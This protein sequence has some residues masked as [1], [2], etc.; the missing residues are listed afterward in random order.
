MSAFGQPQSNTTTS[1]FGQ[2][3]SATSTFGNPAAAAPAFG[4]SSLIK[5]ATAFGTGSSSGGFSAFA[6][7]Q[8]SAFGL[9]AANNTG[10]GS[11]FGQTSTPGTSS[12]SPFATVAQSNPPSAFGAAAQNNQPPAFGSSSTPSTFGNGGSTFGAPSAFGALAQQPT[13]SAFGAQPSTTPAATSA[14]GALAP[15]PTVSAFGSQP[16]T[17]ASSFGAPTATVSAFGNNNAGSAFGASSSPFGG[18]AKSAFGASSNITSAFGASSTFGSSA[19]GTSSKPVAPTP[20]NKPKS[21]PPDFQNA[22]SKYKVGANRY[23]ALLPADYL[24]LLPAPAKEAFESKKFE[25]GKVPEW[26]PPVSLR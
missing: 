14:F 10:G 2:P 13:T 26:I 9:A 21:G 22:P 23:D 6:G 18:G 15:Q 4:Q 11:V 7:Q 1:S 24:E 12:T 17:T 8:T 5:P 16:S 19:F 25:W 20:S 3:A